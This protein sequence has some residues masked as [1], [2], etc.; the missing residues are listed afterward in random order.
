M[1]EASSLAQRMQHLVVTKSAKTERICLSMSGS[2]SSADGGGSA[3]SQTTPG[4]FF[5]PSAVH[6]F[7]FP[8]HPRGEIG[9]RSATPFGPMESNSLLTQGSSRRTTSAFVGKHPSGRC[10]GGWAVGGVRRDG[11]GP[12]GPAALTQ[13]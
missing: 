10:P 11:S 9:R 2:L 7:D 12:E 3:K 4:G 5:G 13:H 6:G 1:V 8:T